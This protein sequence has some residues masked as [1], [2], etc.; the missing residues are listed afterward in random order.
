[1]E[2]NQNQ[3]FWKLLMFIQ[4]LLTL[5]GIYGIC[6]YRKMPV[7]CRDS[8]LQ[9]S[10]TLLS[11]EKYV[12]SVLFLRLDLPSTLIFRSSNRTNEEEE[13]GFFSFRVDGKYFKDGGEGVLAC[14]RLS[15]V[16]DEQT[17]EGER[18]KKRGKTFFLSLTFFFARPQPSRAWSRLRQS[19]SENHDVTIIM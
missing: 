7:V 11:P 9:A 19:F 1:M 6:Q 10:S 4:E 18:E 13:A 2:G 12:K 16:G 8:S 15:V 5:K 3:F 14:S 17:T